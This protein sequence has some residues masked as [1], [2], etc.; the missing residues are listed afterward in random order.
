[1]Q[2]AEFRVAYMANK[3]PFGTSETFIWPEAQAHKRAG[4]YVLFAPLRKDKVFHNSEKLADENV[5]SQGFLTV[6]VLC[7]ALLWLLV[8]PI[9]FWSILKSVASRR[10]KI[11]I[12]NFATIPKGI[13][14]GKQFKK[15]DITHIHAHWLSVPATAALIASIVSEIPYSV[16]A[17]RIDISQGNIIPTKL[18]TSVFVRAIDTKGLEEIRDYDRGHADKAQ[19]VYLGAQ[20]A[21]VLSPVRP[22]E[23]DTVRML[24]AARLVGK[25]GHAWLI[26][27]VALLEKEGQRVSVDLF[28]DGPLEESLKQRAK[29]A[30]VEGSVNFCGPRPHDDLMVALSSGEYDLAVLPSVTDDTGDRE[31]IPAFLM[32]A[33]GAG[34]PVV[35]TDNGGILELIVPGT[36]E[37]VP[38][39]DADALAD[40]IGRVARDGGY[41]RALSEKGRSRMI[42]GFGIDACASHLRVLMRGGALP[43]SSSNAAPSDTAFTAQVSG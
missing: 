34:L 8:N 11:L 38:Q 27:A 20:P 18:R 15:H 10:P 4:A 26:D 24:C 7:V 5:L 16:T 9:K 19:L 40:A 35:S 25:K 30:G 29:E 2:A 43:E 28:G 41:R 12:R 21:E 42:E 6:E 22:G 3:F 17:H 36:G 33:M 14:L 39:K 37:I 1:M 31:G 13:W 32:E 23:L